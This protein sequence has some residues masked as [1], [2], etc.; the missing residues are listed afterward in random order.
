[1]VHGPKQKTEAWQ[2]VDH[3]IGALIK[4]L[5]GQ[6]QFAWLEQPWPDHGDQT[7]GTYGMHEDKCPRENFGFYALIGLVRHS[8]L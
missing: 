3:G 7:N 6:N 2:P 5:A 1:M 4:N 8:I